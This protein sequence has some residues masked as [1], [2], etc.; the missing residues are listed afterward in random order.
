VKLAGR[1]ALVTGA[2][3]G[4][5]SVIALGLA[6]QGADVALLDV[7]ESDGL[8]TVAGEVE[9]G[10]RRAL[11][12]TADVRDVAAVR[13]AV[14]AAHAH[15]G[16]LDVVVNA[17]GVMPSVPFLE[18]E[19]DDW[20]RTLDVNVKGTCFVA[21]AAARHMAAAGYGRIVNVASTRQ[22]QAWPGAA[23]YCASKAGVWMLTRVMA[24]ELAPL[25]IRVNAISPGTIE[26]DLNRH[27]LADPQYR[28]ARLAQI[29]AGRLGTP[30]DLV[31]AVV[32]LSSEDAG[33]IV[34]A[35]LMIDGGQTIW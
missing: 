27:A 22:E 10:G 6:A 25:G 9:R 24:L 21:Q 1:V 34:G 31:A 23:A 16:R 3:G 5:G 13:T 35:S 33:F 29:P 26:T 15:F 20:D 32:L 28:A 17:A 4:L 11:R 8:A 7:A 2:S 19:E 12:L 30:E 18:L 14:D